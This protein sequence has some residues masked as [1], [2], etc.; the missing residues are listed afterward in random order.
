MMGEFSK[1]FM[2]SEKFISERQVRMIVYLASLALTNRSSKIIFISITKNCSL[3]LKIVRLVFQCNIN[4]KNPSNKFYFR[5]AL[6]TK[7][8]P[9]LA[10]IT[11]RK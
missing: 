10:G 4:E 6:F 3:Q 9:R 7:P 2:S 1:Y 11:E 8:T 5:G